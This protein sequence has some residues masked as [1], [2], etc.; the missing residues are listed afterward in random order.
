M[1]GYIAEIQRDLAPGLLISEV[2][3]ADVT[4]ASYDVA[5]SLAYRVAV[6]RRILIVASSE[7]E[8]QIHTVFAFGLGGYFALGG[9]TG[10]LVDLVNK[11]ARGE[12]ALSISAAAHLARSLSARALTSRE[13][14][15]LSLMARGLSN[16]GIAKQFHLTE[17]TVK[18]HVKSITAKLGA[19][20]RT[21]AASIAFR[22]GLIDVSD[23]GCS[24]QHNNGR[25][26]RTRVAAQIATGA[27]M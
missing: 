3:A 13:L 9:G 24:I 27:R 20:G 1:G 5:I 6:P 11:V 10:E 16:K 15:V 12:M 25:A 23:G 22:R 19:R 8:H 26:K 18:S 14:S 7:L 4:I 21:E 17:G 2:D